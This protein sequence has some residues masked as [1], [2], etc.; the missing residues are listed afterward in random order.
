MAKV[1]SMA[2]EEEGQD[3][4]IRVTDIDALN[5]NVKDAVM[6]FAERWIPMP[7]F[8]LDVEAM[9][10]GSLRDAM[11]L[12]ATLEAGDPW[13]TAEKMLLGLGFRWNWFGNIRVMF[14]REREGYVPDD[15]WNDGEEIH[16]D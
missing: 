16:E 9:D 3:I 14:M 7:R 15:G 10:Q 5:E 11:G 1:V 2:K 12:R 6:A 4:P 13:P 8:A